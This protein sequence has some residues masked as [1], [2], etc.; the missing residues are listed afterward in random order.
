MLKALALTLS[1]IVV[2]EA[3]AKEM[4]PTRE[5]AGQFTKKKKKETMWARGLRGKLTNNTS[6]IRTW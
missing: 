5:V 6:Y 2:Y 4:K 3:Q 1:L